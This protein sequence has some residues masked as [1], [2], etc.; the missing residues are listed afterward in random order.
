ME[1]YG[2]PIPL[3]FTDPSNFDPCLDSCCRREE[4]A[5]RK[6]NITKAAIMRHDRVAQSERRRR[7]IV[8]NPVTSFQGCRCC[9]DPTM[10]GGGDYQALFDLREGIRLRRLEQEREEEENAS[11]D[12]KRSREDNHDDDDSDEDSEFDYLLDED[13]PTNS[14]GNS[15]DIEISEFEQRR[16][17]ELEAAA[18]DYETISNH[19][20]GKHVHIHPT[21]VVRA[22]D[23]IQSKFRSIPPASAVVLHL[24]KCTSKTSASL[25]LYLEEYVSKEY[26]GTKFMYCDGQG[27]LHVVEQDRGQLK[28]GA[29]GLSILSKLKREDLPAL[30]LIKN[31]EIVSHV[32]RLQ[33]FTAS[34]DGDEEEQVDV[35]AVEAFLESAGVLLPNA[36]FVED[37]CAIRPEE[38][39]LLDNMRMLAMRSSGGETGMSRRE[40]EELY[41][42]G[43]Q[44]CAKAF[45]HEHVGIKTEE[46]DGLVVKENDI[47]H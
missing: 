46:S 15:N 33:T 40:E 32:P 5:Q 3:D 4:E 1:G 6:Y 34:R 17:Y 23:L 16:R 47:V 24:Y 7:H 26:R 44:G 43:V 20:F 9:Y 10:D 18:L 29:G 22:A 25:D 12:E 30:L 8:S 19:G 38:D 42:C 27:L 11:H 45:Y 35:R 2:G 36:P 28:N 31:G 14:S 37:I 39:A 41:D 21:R 13:L